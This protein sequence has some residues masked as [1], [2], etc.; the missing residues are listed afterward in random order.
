MMTNPA[1]L[2]GNL[3]FDKPKFYPPE[4]E[5]NGTDKC[6]ARGETYDKIMCSVVRIAYL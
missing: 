1:G 6:K 4:I 3:I 5:M 2:W